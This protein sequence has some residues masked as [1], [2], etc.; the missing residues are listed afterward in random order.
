M[1]TFVYKPNKAQNLSVRWA[2]GRDWQ[3]KT[4]DTHWP[5]PLQANRPS[6]AHSKHTCEAS[7]VIYGRISSSSAMR[8]YIA[9]QGEGLSQRLQVQILLERIYN[10]R[11]SSE[12]QTDVHSRE[13]HEWWGAS[14]IIHLH[15]HTCSAVKGSDQNQFLK[16]PAEHLLLYWRRESRQITKIFTGKI[17]FTGIL[18]QTDRQTDKAVDVEC[19]HWSAELNR[20]GFCCSWSS[21]QMQKKIWKN[22]ERFSPGK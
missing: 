20:T 12:T 11:W 1:L 19:V 8:R 16:A 17:S 22:S 14:V 2:S 13:I 15:K 10:Q 5:V 3:V 4:L 9:V 18:L 21:V 7:R 6:L